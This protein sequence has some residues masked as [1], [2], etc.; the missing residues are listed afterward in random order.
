[1]SLNS[2]GLFVAL[3]SHAQTLGLFDQ[4][5]G[6]EAA[7]PP[8]NGLSCAFWGARIAPLPEGSGLASTT[9]VVTFT[10]RIYLPSA[11]PQDSTDPTA[12]SACDALIGVYS[13][14][15]TLGGLVKEVDLLGQSGVPLS[16][17]MGWLEINGIKYRTQDITIPLVINDLWTQAP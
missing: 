13:G 12:L 8:G 10:A 14:D 9:G 4:V 1:M 7:N 3:S 2:A 15:F 5:N 16:G 6:H 17:Q 11:A